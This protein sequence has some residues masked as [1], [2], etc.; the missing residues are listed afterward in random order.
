MAVQTLGRCPK[1]GREFPNKNQWHSRVSYSVDDH[2]Q[3][4]PPSLGETFDSL[5]ER[6]SQFGPIRVDAA[7]TSIN[8]AAK[9][10]FA[11]VQV[12]KSS[13]KLGFTFDTVIDDEHIRLSQKLS[14]TSYGHTVK[15]V[16]K[17]DV[18]AQLLGW[19]EHAY[20]LRR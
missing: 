10:H 15:L 13:L 18:D 16:Q 3:G 8:I 1:C 7:K 19:L 6:I 14:E 12:L 4:K 20:S 11:G 9:S 2:F 17:Q 5:L